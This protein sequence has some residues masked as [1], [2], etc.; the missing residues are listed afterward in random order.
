MFWPG[1]NVEIHGA[2]PSDWQQFSME[3][4]GR[5]RV[6]AIIDWLRR[7]AETRPRFLTL[8]FDTVDTAG[9]RHGPDAPE[10]DAA[11]GE[12]DALIGR[13]IDELAGLNQPANLIFTSDHG[14]APVSAERVIRIDR[15]ADPASFRLI[16]S[17][18]YAAI[19]PTPG[20]DAALAANL[21]KPHPHMQCW[22]RSEMPARFEYG[23]NPRTPSFLCLAETGWTITN[24]EVEPDYAGGAHG[25]DNQDPAMRALF[26]A[27]GP[28]FAQGKT[29]PLADSVDVYPL[30]RRLIG[31]PP[32]TSIDGDDELIPALK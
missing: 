21:L 23:R 32:A 9:H 31:L 15:I 14:M 20:N 7:P 30:L 19:E 5:Q 16:E 2:Y 25:Y 27:H 11:L 18:A 17:G 24:R 28:A 1:S 12:V 29:L 10:T 6:D 4:T 3:V 13:L 8:Y 22:R 26:V